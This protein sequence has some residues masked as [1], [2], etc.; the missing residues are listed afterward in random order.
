MD[1]G[2]GPASA[3]K[4][5]RLRLPLLQQET[6][7]AKRQK[8]PAWIK[9]KIPAGPVY[10]EMVDLV[11]SLGLHTVCQSASCPNIGECWNERAL[12]LMILGNICTR[13]CQFCDVPMGKPLPPDPDEPR[14]VAMALSKLGL[15]HTVITCVDRDD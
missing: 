15:S 14:R 13:S 6:E 1:S 7:P 11:G 2:M 12:T 3:P 4:K 9:A 5:H 8:H 10:E